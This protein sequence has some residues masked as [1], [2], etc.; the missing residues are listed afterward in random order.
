MSD[1]MKAGNNSTQTK[2][3]CIVILALCTV[4][5]IFVLAG[6]VLSAAAAAWLW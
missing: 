2:L 4:N 3:H 5:D 6:R 1:G